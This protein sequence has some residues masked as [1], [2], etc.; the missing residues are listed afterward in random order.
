MKTT[1]LVCLT[2]AAAACGT[3]A[4]GTEST[5]SAGAGLTQAHSDTAS[6]IAVNRDEQT[7][8]VACRADHASGGA[9]RSWRRLG[10]HED[11]WYGQRQRSLGLGT[12]SRR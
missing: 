11:A 12:G 6:S 4:P 7:T 8:L 10:R 3:A 2:L 1:I 5:V 9:A